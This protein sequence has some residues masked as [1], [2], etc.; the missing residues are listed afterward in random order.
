MSGCRRRVTARVL[1]ADALVLCGLLAEWRALIAN[2]TV[3]EVRV[4]PAEAEI[5]RLFAG[6]REELATR[7]KFVPAARNYA[8]TR[9]EAVGLRVN[10]IRMLDLD[11]VRWELGRF[12]KLNVRYGK[13]ARRRGP[14]PRLVP[15]INVADLSPPPHLSRPPRPAAGRPRRSRCGPGRARRNACRTPRSSR[16]TATCRSDRPRPGSRRPGPCRSPPESPRCC[17]GSGRPAERCRRLPARRWPGPG[18]PARTGKAARRRARP[19]RT[20]GPVLAAGHG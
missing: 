10:E 1:Q 15:L 9:L 7:C 14:K 18:P 17:A 8:A 20:A 5:E 12:G 3:P 16:R 6:W 11:D 4:P 13:G 2:M 19:P